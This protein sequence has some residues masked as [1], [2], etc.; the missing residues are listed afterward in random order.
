MGLDELKDTI[1]RKSDITKVTY[2]Y[3]YA[4]IVVNG[5]KSR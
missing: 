4:T 2:L 5:T 3:C 1:M